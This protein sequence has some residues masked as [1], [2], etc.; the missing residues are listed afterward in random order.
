MPTPLPLP[1]SGNGAPATELSLYLKASNR[2]KTDHQRRIYISVLDSA[3]G[4][5]IKPAREC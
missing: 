2:L 5:G 1:Y 3:A 4:V